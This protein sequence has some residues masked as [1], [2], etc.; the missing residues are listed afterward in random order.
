MDDQQQRHGRRQATQAALDNMHEFH[1]NLA[2]Q[3]GTAPR[4]EKEGPA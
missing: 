3:K 1:H 2:D 4:L